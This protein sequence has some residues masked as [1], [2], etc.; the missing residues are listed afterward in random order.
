MS[1]AY[2]LLKSTSAVGRR[3][4][5]PDST[6]RY[7]QTH[8]MPVPNV[9]PT[10]TFILSFYDK[11]C[12]F[13]DSGAFLNDVTSPC[14]NMGL[15]TIENLLMG[16]VTASVPQRNKQEAADSSRLPHV[17]IS[18]PSSF[19]A[20][21]MPSVSSRSLVTNSHSSRL[22]SIIENAKSFQVVF[23]FYAI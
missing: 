7:I 1:I 9:K 8:A 11:C 16:C 23:I 17:H 18:K 15:Q 22:I 12:R 3:P 20:N 2:H 4:I 14:T 5:F 21:G 6:Y 19:S 10:S 13:V